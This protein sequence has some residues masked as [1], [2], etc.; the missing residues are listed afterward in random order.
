[1]LFFKQS[2]EFA[3]RIR[4]DIFDQFFLILQNLLDEQRLVIHK[5]RQQLLFSSGI[6]PVVLRVVPRIWL[7]VHLLHQV[8]ILL[9]RTKE[10]CLR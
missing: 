9:Y 8:H 7:Q 5:A 4:T 6:S 2:Y 1:M 3:T 10:N